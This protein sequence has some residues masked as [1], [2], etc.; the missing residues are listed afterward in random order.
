MEHRT[1]MVRPLP[2]GVVRHGL[3]RPRVR[4]RHGRLSGRHQALDGPLLVAADDESDREHGAR[5]D[6][7]GGGHSRAARVMPGPRQPAH[8][9]MRS[10]TGGVS[11]TASDPERAHHASVCRGERDHREYQRE[12][13]ALAAHLVTVLPAALAD[14]EVV[15]ERAA[16]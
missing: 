1:A 6:R 9:A 11:G 7:A 4:R 2:H 3:V 5:N 14:L 13:A 16:V 15:L 8:R 10:A 12:G